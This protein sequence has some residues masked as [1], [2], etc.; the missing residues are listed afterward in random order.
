MLRIYELHPLPEQ[1]QE[2][3]YGKAL[4][5][6]DE[7]GTETFHFKKSRWRIKTFVV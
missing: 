4:I 2:S 6:V 1:M 7:D 5:H 3:F